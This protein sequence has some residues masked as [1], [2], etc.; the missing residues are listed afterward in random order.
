MAD[1]W[2]TRWA[3]Q[4]ADPCEAEH[5]PNVPAADTI[6]FAAVTSKSRLED[7][8]NIKPVATGGMGHVLQAQHKKTKRLVAIKYLKHSIFSDQRDRA[9]LEYEG[10]I[11][12]KLDHV[13]IV[14][15]YESTEQDGT[16]MLVLEWVEG[17]TLQQFVEARGPLPW[18]EALQL[19]LTITRA[20]KY[21]HEQRVIHRDLKPSNILMTST[22]TLKITDFGLGT[23][24]GRMQDG[25]LP[26]G[27][28]SVAFMAPEQMDHPELVNHLA[29]QFA[30][31]AIGYYLLTG[32]PIR[33]TDDDATRA[34]VALPAQ[35]LQ[36]PEKLPADFRAILVKCLANSPAERYS[37]TAE[38]EREL[39]HFQEGRPVEARPS[40]LMRRIALLVKRTP[41]VSGLLTAFI[42][43]VV[44]GAMWLWSMYQRNQI[45]KENALR[46]LRE[47]VA[48][49]RDFTTLG[50]SEASS[51]TQ[52]T[53][54]RLLVQMKSLEYYM[55]FLER[56]G[57][58][59]RNEVIMT[60]AEAAATL[61]ELGDREK[62]ARCIEDARMLMDGIVEMPLKQQY[63]W[64]YYC[65]LFDD[66]PVTQQIGFMQAMNAQAALYALHREDGD[67][68]RL[69]QEYVQSACAIGRLYAQQGDH[70]NANIVYRAAH[71][72]LTESPHT[73]A[74]TQYLHAQ[75]F[76]ENA[77]SVLQLNNR[78]HTDRWFA[79]GNQFFQLENEHQWRING[80][81]SHVLEWRRSYA[82]YLTERGRH[83][84]VDVLTELER[85]LT[86]S[87]TL[88]LA[89]HERLQH[90]LSTQYRQAILWLRAYGQPC[91]AAA[92]LQRMDDILS[93]LSREQQLSWRKSLLLLQ[94]ETDVAMQLPQL[95]LMRTN[96]FA[97]EMESFSEVERVTAILH[98]SDLIPS[99]LPE[100]AFQL[101]QHCL[102]LSHQLPAKLSTKSL[103]LAYLIPRQYRQNWK[104]EC[105]GDIDNN[106]SREAEVCRLWRS[107]EHGQ[108][109]EP[110]DEWEDGRLQG[111][112]DLLEALQ[113]PGSLTAKMV[114]STLPYR[115]NDLVHYR[116]YTKLCQ[117]IGIS[118]QLS[119]PSP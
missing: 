75:V 24:Q 91:L 72:L 119:L 25:S 69:L 71:G 32:K 8:S 6:V 96:R 11:I 77:Q 108:K 3:A 110:D 61:W 2:E 49:L 74:L 37:S 78:V 109:I 36:W 93:Q 60:M 90:L 12:A 1:N 115:I 117:A 28:G 31:G 19:L 35:E 92:I 67:S 84:A 17:G 41:L 9:R 54:L 56:P 21:A 82:Q 113:K 87:G 45:E 4:P 29:D 47:A 114:T 48:M 79:Q 18:K 107:M 81:T 106:P 39:S 53:Q 88:P 30:L 62:A 66:N 100:D 42:V 111:I 7:F 98:L 89:P 23:V 85:T 118:A 65:A 52:T 40:G 63:R 20:I 27:A 46:L 101:N 68:E 105:S 5:E 104:W 50:T 70:H 16:P 51:S 34:V 22:G 58:V 38:L 59:D 33:S 13:N 102:Q 83:A 103:M 94:L 43:T 10:E 73:L 86:D 55:A 15:L 14:R 80:Y 64:V 97:R 26:P 99:A 112:C 76:T 95:A 57:S 44:I 116:L